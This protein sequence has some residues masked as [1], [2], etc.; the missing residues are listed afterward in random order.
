MTKK[1]YFR[2]ILTLGTLSLPVLALSGC[3]SLFD[4]PTNTDT[5][6]EE[7]PL[8]PEHPP[9]NPPEIAPFLDD[10]QTQLWR[11]GYWAPGDAVGKYIWVPGEIIGRP[12]PT[13][14]W[15][16]ARWVHH[17]YGWTFQHGHWE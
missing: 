10:P 6:K 4:T 17:Q 3:C 12:S 15:A 13:A 9:E 2:I 16:T 14:V 8:L 1:S 7:T 11:P 5:N